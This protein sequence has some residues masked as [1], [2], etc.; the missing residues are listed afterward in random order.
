MEWFLPLPRCSLSIEWFFP[1]CSAIP[2]P[3]RWHQT[4]GRYRRA[5]VIREIYCLIF[6]SA[7]KPVNRGNTCRQLRARFQ[8]VR[9]CFCSIKQNPVS[10]NMYKM[11]DKCP[12]F[13]FFAAGTREDESLGWIIRKKNNLILSHEKHRSRKLHQTFIFEEVSYVIRVWRV[14]WL[15]LIFNI[16]ASVEIN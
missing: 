11:T 3:V 15:P 10:L 14:S 6:E 16:V 13:C 1:R 5:I 8:I 9:W 2:T 12:G 4:C 7:G